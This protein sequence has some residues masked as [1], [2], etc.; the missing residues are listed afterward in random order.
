LKG[1]NLFLG[2][3]SGELGVGLREP[4]GLRLYHFK[5]RTGSVQ[6]TPA[7]AWLHHLNGGAPRSI[8]EKILLSSSDVYRVKEQTLEEA[9][10][11]LLVNGPGGEFELGE[12]MRVAVGKFQ[13]TAAYAPRQVSS[14]TAQC[15]WGPAKERFVTG[16]TYAT[17]HTPTLP[18]RP[19][20]HPGNRHLA[21]SGK[22]GLERVFRKA[23]PPFAKILCHNLAAFPST[24]RPE[25]TFQARH[26]IGMGL[27]QDLGN[28]VQMSEAF[29]QTTEWPREHKE[30]QDFWAQL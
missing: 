2:I 3:V 12:W 20:N 9:N 11:V 1:K 18:D 14:T 21:I 13:K 25:F 29:Y 5:R 27:A 15:L 19:N 17:L 30:V 23:N 7:Y 16:N 8:A 28:S 24:I 10:L 26:L 6:E 22:T 4:K